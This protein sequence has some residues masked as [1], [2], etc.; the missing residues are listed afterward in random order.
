MAI[1]EVTGIEQLMR[2]HILP[3]QIDFSDP[4]RVENLRKLLDQIVPNHPVL[5]SLLG[6]T[7]ANFQDDMRLLKILSRLMRDKDLLLIEV[8][9][10]KD[11]DNQ[12]VQAAAA[13]YARIESFKKFVTS[14]LLQ[15]TDLH[16]DLGNLIFQS[17]V[18]DNKAILIKVIYQNSTKETIRVMLPDWSYTD[19]LS[20]D[21]IRLLLTRKYTCTGIEKIISES[22]LA[23]VD[24]KNTSFENDYNTKFGM[25]LLLVNRP[26]SN[27]PGNNNGNS[28]ADAVWS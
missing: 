7:L 19:F 20:N 1:Q 12:T 4:R 15:N 2:R 22:G 10:T 23:I 25:D 6:N 27:K 24:R 21:T 13:E 26:S 5:F 11:L 14:A 16:I 3:I 8:A 9:A 17:S 28:L 18:E